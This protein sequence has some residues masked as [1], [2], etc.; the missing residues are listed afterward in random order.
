MKRLSDKS[1]RSVAMLLMA[2]PKLSAKQVCGK[3]D[4]A[5]EKNP[6]TAPIPISWQ[7]PSVRSWIES[8]DRFPKRVNTFISKVRKEAGIAQYR[9]S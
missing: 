6:D 3:L 7:N 5:H 4:N 8:Y 9:D 1:K 2:N